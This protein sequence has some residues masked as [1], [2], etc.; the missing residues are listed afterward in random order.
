L[1]E[2]KDKHIIYLLGC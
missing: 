1:N 2:V